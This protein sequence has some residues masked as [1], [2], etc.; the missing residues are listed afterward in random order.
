MGS[1]HHRNVKNVWE[2]LTRPERCQRSKRSQRLPKLPSLNFGRRSRQIFLFDLS[3]NNDI[4][5][6]FSVFCVINAGI[7]DFLILI[8]ITVVIGNFVE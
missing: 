5:I 7:S 2:S 3:R 6:I 1:T 4:D 8:I